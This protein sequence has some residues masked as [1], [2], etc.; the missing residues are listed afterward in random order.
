ML[1]GFPNNSDTDLSQQ[2]WHK[3]DN[4]RLQ[5]YFYIMTLSALLE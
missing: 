3:V 4:V 1:Q 2:D 5:Q